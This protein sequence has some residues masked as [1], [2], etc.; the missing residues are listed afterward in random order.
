M[1][2]L[3]IVLFVLEM[4]VHPGIK[5]WLLGAISGINTSFTQAGNTSSSA[6]PTGIPTQ[7]VP[8]PIGG[9]CPPGFA[10]N[11]GTGQCQK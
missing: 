11:P 1:I 8:R 7:V 4:V 2:V 6:Q 5:Q 3:L 9:N 10:F